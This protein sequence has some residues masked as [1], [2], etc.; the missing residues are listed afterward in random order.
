MMWFVLIF[1]SKK[2]KI[3]K[4]S[5]ININPI[6]SVKEAYPTINNTIGNMYTINADNKTYFE[7]VSI[8]TLSLTFLL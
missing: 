4:E 1:L 8:I 7:F 5:I 3:I 6:Y 2:N